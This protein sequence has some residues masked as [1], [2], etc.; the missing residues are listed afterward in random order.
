MLSGSFGGNNMKILHLC[1]ANFYIDNYSYQENIL[2]KFHKKL[3]YDVE[4]VASLISFDDN[5]KTCLLEKGSQYENEY[6]IPITRLDYSN[7]KFSRRLRQYKGTYDAI[8]RANHDII[9]IHGCQFLDIKYVVKFAKINP[10]VKIFVDNHAD[11]S[12]S[13]KTFMSKN[14]LHKV[15]WKHCAHLIEPY[16]TMFYGVL[17]ARV[18]FLRNIFKL[19]KEKVELLVM[20]AD[21]EKVEEAKSLNL[22]NQIRKKYDI[23]PSDFLIVTGGKIDN[24]KKQTLLLMKAVKQI[25]AK[26]VR[27][28]IFGSIINELKEEVNALVDGDRI[29]YIGWIKSEDSYKHFA[30]ADLVVFPGR[31]SVFWEQVVGLGVPCFFKYWHGTTH[32]D[33]G[34]NCMFL[35]EESVEEMKEKIEILLNDE[36]IFR[37][38]KDSAETKGVKQFSY[39][40]IAEQSL[41][42]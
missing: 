40:R 17:P 18:D 20:G 24:A 16:T 39:L 27:L 32:V 10:N 11:F 21:D 6:G 23:K 13:A 25:K 2:P 33:V 22:R 26:Q 8:V 30:A 31:H 29:Q 36:E 12:N 42:V 9:F 3:G 38:M 28:I 35:H 41:R 5:G 34:D 19:P 7:S 4:V 1:L 37:K 15:I 14:I